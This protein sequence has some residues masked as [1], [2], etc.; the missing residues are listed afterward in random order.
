MSYTK[1]MTQAIGAYSA[2]G[3]AVLVAPPARATS[4]GK[5]TPTKTYQRSA[6]SVHWYKYYN[7]PISRL[8]H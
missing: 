5:F 1:S 7:D 8:A 6:V 4:M 3:R 2:E